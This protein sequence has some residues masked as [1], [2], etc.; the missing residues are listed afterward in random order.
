MAGCRDLL[1]FPVV[2][3]PSFEV[4]STP[5]KDVY[6]PCSSTSYLVC[7]NSFDLESRRDVWSH[8]GHETS[9]VP[10]VGVLF[11]QSIPTS[12]F[13]GFPA[14]SSGILLC[15]CLCIHGRCR[16]ALMNFTP[17]LPSKPSTATINPSVRRSTTQPVAMCVCVLLLYSDSSVASGVP[18]LLNWQ[19]TLSYPKHR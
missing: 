15:V 5:L 12:S 9:R 11:Q 16:H 19:G 18:Y 10:P 7:N 3:I 8:A 4:G 6:H 1:C 14:Q 17:G 13:G 2:F